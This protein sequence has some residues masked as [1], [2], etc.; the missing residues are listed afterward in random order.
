M[1]PQGTQRGGDGGVWL[2]LKVI[3]PS[4]IPYVAV[5]QQLFWVS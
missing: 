4:V 2:F 1:S 5:A 3:L